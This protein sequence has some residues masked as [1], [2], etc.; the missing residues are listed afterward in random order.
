LRPVED[1]S[2]DYK[3]LVR[4]GYD[5]CAS[6]YA[7]A[8]GQD[9]SDQLAPLLSV[10]PNQ[11][12]VLDLGCGAGI[13]IAQTLAKRHRVTGVDVSQKMLDMAKVAVPDGRFI[14]SDISDVR[15]A[16]ASFDAV[17]AIFVLFHLPR[18][19]I[20]L[21]CRCTGAISAGTSTQNVCRMLALQF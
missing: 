15:F 2:V 14:C 20:S 5:G 8:R 1:P 21:A 18:R 6:D 3:A 17:L 7:P 19:M 16:D 4:N 11:S 12:Q 10:L 13:P 9:D